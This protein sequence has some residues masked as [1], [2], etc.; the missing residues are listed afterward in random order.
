MAG[1]TY[2]IAAADLLV[3]DEADGIRDGVIDLAN[4]QN[5]AS[6]YRFVGADAYDQSGSWVLSAGS[7]SSAGDVD[8][9]GVADLLIGAPGADGIGN[10]KGGCWRNLSDFGC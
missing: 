1:E 7:V 10:G 3:L 4:V 6:S 2:L 5:G 9:D 8:R